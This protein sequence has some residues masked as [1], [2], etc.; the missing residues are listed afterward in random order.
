MKPQDL[1]HEVKWIDHN[2]CLAAEPHDWAKRSELLG[3]RRRLE[4][5]ADKLHVG[6]PPTPEPHR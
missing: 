5:V 4:S 2:L 1:L 6:L 3:K